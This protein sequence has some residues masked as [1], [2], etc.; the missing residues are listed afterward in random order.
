MPAPKVVRRANHQTGRTSK[1]VDVQRL[2]LGPGMR[3]S[4]T[5]KPYYEGRKNR[6]DKSAA[7]RL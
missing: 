4:H 2:A 7:K 3:I 1:V 5:G 6:S